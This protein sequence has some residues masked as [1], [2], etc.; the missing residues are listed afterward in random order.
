MHVSL[1]KIN[2]YSHPP[3]KIS[4]RA[5]PDSCWRS[6]NASVAPQTLPHV[7]P[8]S[9]NSHGT[10]FNSASGPSAGVSR[11]IQVNVRE[12][13]DASAG[14]EFDIEIER[15]MA[16]SSQATHET[17]L[18]MH[19]DSE[20][21]NEC[22]TDAP[23]SDCASLSTDYLEKYPSGE[24][25]GGLNTH[26]IRAEP[27]LH[28]PSP[29]VTPADL[30][31]WNQDSISSSG[32]CDQ[33]D[34]SPAP[35]EVSLSCP[36]VLP[37]PPPD[38]PSRP[39]IGTIMQDGSAVDDASFGPESHGDRV[40][41]PEDRVT[42]IQSAEVDEPSISQTISDKD[43]RGRSTESQTSVFSRLGLQTREAKQ[44][45]STLASKPCLRPRR[46]AKYPR[47]GEFPSVS[48]IIPAR[49][50]DELVART[51]KH[52]PTRARSCSH[53]GDSETDSSN[54]DNDLEKQTLMSSTASGGSNLKARGR[55]RRRP[56]RAQG[57][58]L[59]PRKDS[60]GKSTSQSQPAPGGGLA[61]TL[62]KSQEIF[63]RG[64]LRI[65][66]HGPRHVYFMTFLPE[67]S[68]SPSTSSPSEIPPEHP[69]RPEEFLNS[70]IP[71]QIGRSKRH[72]RDVTSACED[73]AGCSTKPPRLP[74][75]SSFR[76]DRSKTQQPRRR[77]PWSPEEVDYLRQ[78]R[79][80]EQRPW[81]EVLRLFSSQY[82][83]RS[84]GAIQ[85][86]WSTTIRNNRV[87]RYI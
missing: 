80:T 45:L 22:H 59:S 23:Q 34:N 77:F 48:V 39:S 46:V 52:P 86:Y 57:K 5:F 16:L 38:L 67:I 21:R 3:A 73:E 13:L 6:Y 56:K 64:V 25:R 51:R 42:T 18:N 75:H 66:A 60:V 76:E 55:P 9:P 15:A 28:H 24:P 65:Q 49:R 31:S 40:R 44:S 62:D 78:L 20:L 72:Q 47:P 61:V 26:L 29:P 32:T 85:V 43:T 4:S 30:L 54:L 68:H 81:S 36:R 8:P 2:F 11:E 82:P 33:T 41:A 84:P 58:S 63:G 53:S 74:P 50:N 27:Q 71:R 69:S 79:S 12:N 7:L 35:P 83:G 17:D 37:S 70:A 10:Y 19:L 87:R 14:S 1:D